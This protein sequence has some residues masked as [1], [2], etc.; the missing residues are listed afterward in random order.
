MPGQ[1][2]ASS[3]QAVVYTRVS[4][5]EQ[6]KEGFSIPAQQK[7]LQS[8]AEDQGFNVVREFVDV[9]TAKRAGRSGFDEMTAF[10]RRNHAKCRTLLVEKTDRLYRNLK[11]YVT[12]D[13]LDLDIHLVKENQIFSRDSR[14][15]EK[16]M[17]GMKVL[18]AKNYIDNLSEEARKGML[19][20][21][22]QGTW[23]SYAP[24]GYKNVDGDNG[25]KIVVPDPQFAPIVKRLYVL[26]SEGTYSVKELATSLGSEGLHYRSGNKMATAT[27]HKILRNRVYSG[28]FEWAG[29]VFKG[30]YEPLV[31]LDLWNR[32]QAVLDQRLAKRSKKNDHNFLFTGLVTCGH[33]GCALVGEIKKGKYIYYHCTGFKGKCAEP[34][35]REEVLESDFSHLLRKLALDQEIADWVCTALKESHADERKLHDEA[36]ARLK[37]EHQRLGNRL[38]TLYEDK[39]DGRIDSQFY[40]RKS[41]DW[42]A[43]QSK[44][45]QLIGD[46]E[47]AEQSYMDEG[48]RIVEL[49]QKAGDLFDKQ[50]P[51]EKRRLL[52]CV[53][54]GA[55]WKEGALEIQFRQPFD[56]LIDAVA[57]VEAKQ[58]ARPKSTT[59]NPL[60]SN[61]ASDTNE[62]PNGVLAGR[63]EDWLPDMDSNH[64]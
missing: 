21:A 33:C 28:Q 37:S 49:A 2:S 58:A 3:V 14:S 35:V 56:M 26:C 59:E 54:S 63:F 57:I 46:H 62:S 13:E 6:E 61:S 29:R 17:H 55:T 10:L 36:I 4:S 11:D 42:R 23:P 27:V 52:N 39:L 43:E 40:D 22:E 48:V 8:Y 31:S 47:K 19:E 41:K 60:L 15:A 45:L 64:D 30:T 34:Y 53:M 51:S 32:V 12:L 9:E 7:L 18:M 20:K 25:K 50:V 44:L 1:S 38:E 16:F 5:K 24:L